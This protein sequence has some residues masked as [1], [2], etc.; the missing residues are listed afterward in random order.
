MAFNPEILGRFPYLRIYLGT[1]LLSCRL[2][3]PWADTVRLRAT[4]LFEAVRLLKAKQEA[5]CLGV[6][7]LAC[8]P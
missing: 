7:V 5:L 8:Y 2:A 3:P 4:S 6:L 1:Y